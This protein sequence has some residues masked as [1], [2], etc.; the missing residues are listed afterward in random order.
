LREAATIIQDDLKEVGMRVHVAPFDF[1]AMVDRIL[2]THDYEAGILTFESADPIAELNVWLS[3]GPQH[4]WQPRQAKPSTPWEAEVDQ[5]MRAQMSML[6]PAARKRAYD[7]VQEIV[8]ANVPLIFLVAPNVLVGAR[9]GLGNFRP[10]I[11]DHHLLWN[12][13]ELFWSAAAQRT[14]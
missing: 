6:D 10:V 3:S 9:T 11:L 1:R 8:A 4:L 5:L 14:R 7:R 2:N 13:E 12:V